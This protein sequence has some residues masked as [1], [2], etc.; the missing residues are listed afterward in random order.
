[1]RI[2]KLKLNNFRNFSEGEV[3]IGEGTTVFY[4]GVGE[5]KTNLIEAVFMLSVG[6]SYR[7]AETHQVITWG[8]NEACVRGEGQNSSGE[9]AIAVQVSKSGKKVELNGESNKRSIELIGGLRT[10]LFHG[11]DINIVSGGPHARRRFLDIA[12]SQAS[13]NYAYNLRDYYRILKQRNSALNQSAGAGVCEWDEQLATTGSWLTQ[14]RAKVIKEIGATANLVIKS[15]GGG[16]NELKLS[17]QPSGE[18]DAFKF[19][20]RLS[21]SLS[22]DIA[23]GATTVGPHR[24]DFKIVLSGVDARNFASSGERKTIVLALKLAEVEFLKAVTGEKPILLLDDV[25]SALDIKRSKALLGVTGDGSQ[26]I[27][28]LTDLNLLR[29]E[30][31][32]GARLYEV[33]QGRIIQAL[34]HDNA[35]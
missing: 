25:F 10:V 19:K 31:R 4:G 28:T 17:Y 22:Y 13:K 12:L 2:K 35:A 15:L 26:C 18:T 29:D 27:V 1:M 20:M 23:R 32:A 21:R 5:G 34:E 24:D 33:R 11:E 14:I 3:A 7:T 16:D 8:Q 9:F 6:R 30:F